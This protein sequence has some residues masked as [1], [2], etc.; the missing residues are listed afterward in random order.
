MHKAEH[1]RDSQEDKQLKFALQ[2]DE[3]D[4]ISLV[5]LEIFQIKRSLTLDQKWYHGRE[6]S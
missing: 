3:Y 4:T 1:G 5:K 6:H 2:L